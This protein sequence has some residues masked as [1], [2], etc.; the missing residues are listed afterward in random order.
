MFKISLQKEMHLINIKKT[1]IGYH[2]VHNPQ[3]FYHTR[4]TGFIFLSDCFKNNVE[5][6]KRN[7]N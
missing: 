6:D 4:K 2:T 1:T 5:L 7:V 3:Y